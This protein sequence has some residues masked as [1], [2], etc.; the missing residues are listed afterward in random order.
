MTVNAKWDLAAS[1]TR[2][3]TTRLVVPFATWQGRFAPGR[4]IQGDFATQLNGVTFRTSGSVVVVHNAEQDNGVDHYI[5]PVL[6]QS[7]AKG[8]LVLHSIFAS[9]VLGPS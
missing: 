4:T 7:S 8:A 1:P 2:V 5:T 9:F 3:P 6:E